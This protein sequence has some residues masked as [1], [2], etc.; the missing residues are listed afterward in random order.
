MAAGEVHVWRAALDPPAACVRGL[1]DTLAADE[2]ARADRFVSDRDRSRYIVARGV[3][4]AVLGRCLGLPPGALAFRYS[5]FGKPALTGDAAATD[6]RFN[7]SHAGG[8]ALYAV[9]RGREI[10]VDLERIRPDFATDEIARRFFSPGEVAALRALGPE[11]RSRAFFDCWTR[12]EAYIKAR[13]EGLS[14]PLDRFEVSLAPGA[15][16]ALLATGEDPDEAARW[17]LRALCPGPGY[18]AALAVEGQSWHLQCWQWPE[19]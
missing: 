5:A 14:R 2:R 18:A 17:S 8:L 19:G 6:L 12:K 10:G 9:A 16:A 11:H 13:G 3:L 7:V 4:R 15:P 1:A